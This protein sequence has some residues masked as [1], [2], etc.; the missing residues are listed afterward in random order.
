M[1]EKHKEIYQQHRD[2]FE[3][4]IQEK[5]LDVELTTIRTKITQFESIE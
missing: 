5:E 4:L 3:R 2:E 1:A